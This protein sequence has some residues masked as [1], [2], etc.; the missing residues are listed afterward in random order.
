MPLATPQ[1]IR[2]Q[3]FQS[4]L[5]QAPGLAS[6]TGPSYTRDGVQQRPPAFRTARTFNYY[7]YLT[8]FNTKLQSSLRL[9]RP[10][11]GVLPGCVQRPEADPAAARA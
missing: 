11:S 9:L 10:S 3:A 8:V 4:P 6:D 1:S 5:W 2:S 7:I